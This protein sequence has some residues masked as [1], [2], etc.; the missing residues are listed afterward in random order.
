MSNKVFITGCSG[1]T[2]RFLAEELKKSGYFVCGGDVS[3]IGDDVAKIDL[4]DI[5]S[6]KSALNLFRPD[7]IIHLAGIAFVAHTNSLDMYRIN[8]LGTENLFSAIA[9]SGLPIKKVIVASSSNVYGNTPVGF[10]TE[11]EIPMPITHY[12][13]SKLAMEYIT[14]TW[15]DRIPVVVV[16]PFNYTGIG[17]GINFVIPKIVSAFLNRMP[18]IKLGNLDVYREFNDVRYVARCYVSLMEK[19]VPGTVVNIC[20]GLGYCL[21]DILKMMS[22]ITSHTPDIEI[23]PLL[24]RS[25]EISKLV[26]SPYN[27]LQIT[28]DVSSINLLETLEWMSNI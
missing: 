2:G 24:V 9:E 15:R 11:N 14:M 3:P 13:I 23:D 16:R 1:F 12:A 18:V 7:Y 27:M 22:D 28:G 10:V 6:L 25:S 17:Q 8:L 19:A 4:S 5:E 26:G 21:R 20:T